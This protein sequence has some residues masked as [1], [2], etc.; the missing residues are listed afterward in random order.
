M[1]SQPLANMVPAFPAMGWPGRRMQL[2]RKDRKSWTGSFIESS[3][4]S[5]RLRQR[6]ATRPLRSPKSRGSAGMAASAG[7]MP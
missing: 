2:V 6:I 1:H 5:V 7:V 4:D 3:N